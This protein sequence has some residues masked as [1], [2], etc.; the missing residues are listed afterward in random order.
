MIDSTRRFSDRVALYAE[1]RPAYPADIFRLH[2]IECG[3]EPGAVV[4]DIGSG[5]AQLA[6]LFLKAPAGRHPDR[7]QGG[8]DH[9]GGSIDCNYRVL[10]SSAKQQRI[11]DGKEKTSYVFEYFTVQ[12]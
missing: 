9:C 1:H 6:K 5:T 8:I 11:I 7:R 12:I 3:L 4:A 10:N 2:K